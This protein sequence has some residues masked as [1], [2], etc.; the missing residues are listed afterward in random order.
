M[1]VSLIVVLLARVVNV[2]IGSWLVNWCSPASDHISKLSQFVLWFSGLRGGVAF[3]LS[4]AATK[5]LKN[6]YPGCPRGAAYTKLPRPHKLPHGSLARVLRLSHSGR[7]IEVACLFIVVVSIF[8][9]GG[10]IGNTPSCS[11]PIASYVWLDTPP[12]APSRPMQAPWSGALT[13]ASHRHCLSTHEHGLDGAGDAPQ[14][15]RWP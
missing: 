11:T 14:P 1:I 3:A 7:L 15:Q 10:T 12:R 8:S 9:I 13:C 6:R 5:V 4:K 2:G